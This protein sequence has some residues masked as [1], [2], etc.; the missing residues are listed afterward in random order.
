MAAQNPQSPQ[1]AQGSSSVS[2]V[3]PTIEEMFK[4]GKQ[5]VNTDEN[6]FED[7]NITMALPFHSGLVFGSSPIKWYFPVEEPHTPLDRI[8]SH[9][10]PKTPF[11]ALQR[12]PDIPVTMRDLFAPGPLPVLQRTPDTPVTTKDLVTPVV[13]LPVTIEPNITEGESGTLIA[14]KELTATNKVSNAPK[15]PSKPK[16]SKAPPKPKA[17]EAPENLE[18]LRQQLALQ[19]TLE[20]ELKG[21][22]VSSLEDLFGDNTGEIPEEVE[23]RLAIEKEAAQERREIQMME[24]MQREEEE[25]L[26]DM[27]KQKL[28][29]EKRLANEEE[30]MRKKT[31]REEDRKKQQAADITE[32]NGKRRL[33]A[34]RI[35]KA[36]KEEENVAKEKDNGKI[37]RVQVEAE[38]LSN[39]GGQ[40][41]LARRNLGALVPDEEKSMFVP[42]L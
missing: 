1:K 16:V 33:V 12:T 5:A 37:P 7:Q 21:L 26:A 23:A 34:E 25:R 22:G 35:E 8:T 36:R 11:L 6:Q 18:A 3:A 19:R 9:S 31:R 32:Q 4:R 28:A 17:R 24:L 42:G 15:A 13:K 40:N 38:E 39:I 41:S 30:D 2:D 29:Q 10:S 20:K 14:G 27:E